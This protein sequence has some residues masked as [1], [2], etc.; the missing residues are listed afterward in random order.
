MHAGTWSENLLV[1]LHQER[2]KKVAF[3]VEEHRQCVG[4]W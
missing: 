1:V 4:H 3:A 2:K